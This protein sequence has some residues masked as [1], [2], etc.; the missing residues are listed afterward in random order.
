[1]ERDASSYSMNRWQIDRHVC[2]HF[3]ALF[4]LIPI[5]MNLCMIN[6]VGHFTT[7]G[8]MK[9]HRPMTYSL[10]QFDTAKHNT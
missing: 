7:K 1:M 8:F 10:E 9:L 4:M 2:S 5:V 6:F 3:D